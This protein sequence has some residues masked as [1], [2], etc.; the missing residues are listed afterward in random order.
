[1]PPV[2]EQY[3]GFYP[4]YLDSES[5]LSKK[6]GVGHLYK[7]YPETSEPVAKMKFSIE[8]D[9]YLYEFNVDGVEHIKFILQNITTT[10]TSYKLQLESSLWHHAALVMSTESGEI[11]KGETTF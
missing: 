8:L 1:M 10:K 9:G 6:L 11:L 7:S 2:I 5:D 4:D 3:F